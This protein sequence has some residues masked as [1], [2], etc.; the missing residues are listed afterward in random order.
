M[1]RCPLDTKAKSYIVCEGVYCPNYI[2]VIA[3]LQ[4]PANHKMGSIHTL[5]PVPPCILFE[6]EVHSVLWM[7]IGFNADPD[8]DLAIFGQGGVQG[9][10]KNANAI[11]TYP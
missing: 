6:A 7:R 1:G 2:T 10:G 4:K 5:S 8:P 11:F 9:L 3:G